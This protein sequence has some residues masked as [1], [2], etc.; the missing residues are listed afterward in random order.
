M[1]L[2]LILSLTVG[3]ASF[4]LAKGNP[5]IVTDEGQRVQNVLAYA[6]LQ[7]LN[8]EVDN[9]ALTLSIVVDD[10]MNKNLDVAVMQKTLERIFI[11]KTSIE[12]SLD[13]GRQK[14]L[15][16]ALFEMKRHKPKLTQNL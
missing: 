12:G 5:N 13:H 6:E 7:A 15:N 16:A 2:L 14:T 9:A 3:T 11:L 1:K 10:L 8:G 4:S